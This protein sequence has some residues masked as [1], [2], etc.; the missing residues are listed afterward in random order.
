MTSSQLGQEIR[1]AAEAMM[2]DLLSAVSSYMEGLTVDD[3]ELLNVQTRLD[4]IENM[5]QKFLNSK[6]I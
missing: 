4:V 5:K 1:V 3:E 6:N 2:A